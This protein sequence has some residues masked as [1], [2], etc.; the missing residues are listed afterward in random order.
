MGRHES[1]LSVLGVDPGGAAGVVRPLVELHPE[2]LCKADRR[3]AHGLNAGHAAFD[4]ER[5][6]NVQ[7]GRWQQS[8]FCETQ[9]KPLKYFRKNEH[10]LRAVGGRDVFVGTTGTAETSDYGGARM[11]SAPS[12]MRRERVEAVD[13]ERRAG[14]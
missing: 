2:P 6:V 3:S 5:G 13:V 12:P 11:A 9:L 4:G 14:Q 1:A 10:N 7:A 8:G